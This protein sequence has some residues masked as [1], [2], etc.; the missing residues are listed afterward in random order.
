MRDSCMNI[1][2]KA[3]NIFCEELN[4]YWSFIEMILFL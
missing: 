3:F 4:D 2:L 1:V